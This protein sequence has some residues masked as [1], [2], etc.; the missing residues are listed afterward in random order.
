MR[1]NYPIG[2]YQVELLRRLRDDG[3]WIDRGMTTACSWVYREPSHMRAKFARLEARGLVK[4]AGKRTTIT[5][6]GREAL[7][8]IEG[9]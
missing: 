1:K 5:K 2:A 3:P 4:T 8:A 9:A 7:A 6:A